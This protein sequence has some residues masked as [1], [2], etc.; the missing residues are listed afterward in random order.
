MSENGLLS[1][2]FPGLTKMVVDSFKKDEEGLVVVDR[3]IFGKELT[4]A[5]MVAKIQSSVSRLDELN[6]KIDE[7]IKAGKLAV[8]TAKDTKGVRATFGLFESK[9][10][11]QAVIQ[12]MQNSDDKQAQAIESLSE[13]Q[14]VQF[15]FQEDIAFILKGL[16]IM[17]CGSLAKNRMVVRELQ[18]RLNGA[19]DSD[20]DKLAQKELQDIIDQLEQQRDLLERQEQLGKNTKENAENIAAN[21]KKIETNASGVK[22]NKKAIENLS[23]AGKKQGEEIERNFKEDKRRD[24]VIAALAERVALLEA[25]KLNTKIPTVVSVI[26]LLIAIAALTVALIK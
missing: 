23:T 9:S 17:G 16:F 20:I 11:A 1:A 3:E 15:K 4:P 19:S 25:K 5:E 21:R 7:A 24:E 14:E 22:E 10:K 2:F 12:A 26:G 18:A 8:Q 6:K 13:A